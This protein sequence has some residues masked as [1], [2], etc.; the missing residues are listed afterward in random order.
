M[1]A[2]ILHAFGVTMYGYYDNMRKKNAMIKKQQH[3]DTERIDLFSLFY[4]Y[5]YL[6]LSNF[7]LRT[8]PSVN[9]TVYYRRHKNWSVGKK[10][11]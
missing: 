1:R 4:H 10:I 6:I 8:T 7:Q 3:T 9:T 11:G 2:V 5:Y